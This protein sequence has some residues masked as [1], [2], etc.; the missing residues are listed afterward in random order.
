MRERINRLAKG[1][2]DP[3]RPEV[4]VSPESVEDT[5]PAGEVTRGKLFVSDREGRFIKGLAYSSNMRVHIHNE[6]F[7]GNRN[8]ITYEVDG[9]QLSKED[10]IA[11][12]FYLVTNGGE[13]KVPFSFAIDPGAS[14]RVLEG[15]KEPADF[16]QLAKSDQEL[17][18]RLFE[19]QDFT[20]APFM[21]D[22]HVRALYDG[23]R[24]RLNRQ[25]Q[26]EEFLVALRVKQPVRLT[27]DQTVR[28]YENLTERQ[29]AELEVRMETWGYVQ[30]DVS[31][32]GDF[33]EIPK[34]SFHSQDFQ[35]GV[36]TVRYVMNPGRLH[37][38]RN[39]GAVCISSV[40]NRFSVPVEAFEGAER[41][42]VSRRNG[43]AEL[44][45]Y[46]SYRLDYETAADADPVLLKQKRRS[47][48][49]KMEE[50]LE[51]LREKGGDTAPVLLR[52]AELAY[53]RQDME[54][55]AELL[56]SC[57][58][59]INQHRLEKRVLYCAHQ[60]LL[61]LV[62]QREGQR[63]AIIRVVNRA[64]ADPDSEYEH[65]GLYLILLK[66]Q[67]QLSE[68]PSNVLD[69]LRQ[70]FDSGC[71]SPWLYLEAWKRY[72]ENPALL[73]KLG[74][75][76]RQV[77]CFAA[78]RQLVGRDLALRAAQLATVMKYYNRV[79]CRLFETLYE[80]YEEQPIL[81]AVCS[82]LIRGDR[83]EESCFDWYRKALEAGISLTRLY[84]YFLYAL[85]KDYPYL[86]PK[87]VLMY[88]SYDRNMDEESRSRLYVN[89]I[90]YMNPETP[91]YK[92]YER[93]IEKFTME[94]LLRSR[95]TRQLVV[96]Y[97]H[98][99]YREMI[100]ERVARV[101]PSILKS[102]RIRVK[103]PNIRYVVV[104]YEEIEGE[105]AFPVTNGTAYVPLFSHRPLILFQDAYGN[106]YADIS[107]RKLP[108]LERTDIS[109]LEDRCYEVHP[110]HTMLRLKECGEIAAH[111][112]SGGA[113]A[114]ALKKAI[115]DLKLHPLFRRRILS[116]LI[117]YYRGQLD[118]KES[119]AGENLDFLSDL[120]LAKLGR[121]ERAGAC[122]ALIEQGYLR[123]AFRTV[124]EY[125]CEG[126][127]TARL[128][129]LCSG[130]ILRGLFEEEEA[131]VKLCCMLFSDNQFDGA[132]LDYLCEHFNGST[133]QMFRILSQGVHD[134]VELSDLPER[135]L[136]QMM[137]S[138]ET[139]RIDQVFDWYVDG[140][141]TSELVM[142]A[143]FTWKS[144]DYFLREKDTGVRVF[145][146]LE[147]VVGSAGDRSRIPTI[148]LLALTKYYSTL[149][150]LE[151]ERQ[152]LAA[153]IVE[154]LLGEGRVFAY[155]QDLGRLMPLPDSIMDKVIVEYRGGRES[156]P[157]L[158][159]RILPDEEEFACE[160]MQKVYPG[161]YVWQKVL[162]E[163]ELLEYQIY[164]SQDGDRRMVRE[165]S[166][167]CDVN[168][169]K[170]ADSRFS[171]L[172]EMSL[173]LSLKEEDALKEKMRKYVTDGAM[174]E[175][176]FGI[177]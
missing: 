175:E 150:S 164:E 154:L 158:S 5:I 83:R 71:H 73:G 3:D 8:H 53:L 33:I 110:N 89:I 2:V 20:E 177:M 99:I 155:F 145:A 167:S 111:G 54:K 93:E 39:L 122:E 25:N 84:E 157:E 61:Y 161:I 116:L 43:Q 30:F 47:L 41:G 45:R 12:A 113:D 117:A 163:G 85:P 50:E 26:L 82:I 109:A 172:N 14:G 15:L 51:T 6:S 152:E 107:Y 103:N 75:F 169:K 29:E 70:Y 149:Q 129:K 28:H 143:Y 37:M 16:A 79:A 32:E 166:V 133:R 140:R 95:I 94:Q 60:Y 23:L 49:E 127:Q 96:L 86:L 57:R 148:Y 59:E 136:A 80:T 147:G 40:K 48:A 58:G 67:P 4:V 7:G 76:E 142:K 173:C 139:D 19:Y 120:D 146:Y 176:L 126:I 69:Q 1:I 114:L 138:G 156:H 87:E 24:S 11:G 34:K 10:V 91:L 56:E 44:A 108:A 98:M 46:L 171:A 102:Y 123:D 118:D 63:E 162:F 55:T 125:G 31:A 153:E 141:R 92:Q 137:F 78:R 159:V 66:L 13:K 130:L 115:A 168:Q 18:L 65:A 105:D 160:E 68:E 174:M 165:E 42:A 17:A 81:S 21:Q 104:C 74:S 101:L 151:P 35:N 119:L 100:D 97:D 132:M 106:R 135:L 124:S 121:E 112:I 27:C 9:R 170:N 77:L 72:E 52:L 134:H 90:R 38:G 131:L 64:I 36:C 62:E 128:Q 22:L 144:A 88:F